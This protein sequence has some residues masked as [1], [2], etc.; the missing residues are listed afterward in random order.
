[1]SLSVSAVSKNMGL[2]ASSQKSAHSTSLLPLEYVSFDTFYAGKKQLP[3]LHTRASI[4]QRHVEA[5]PDT[6][7][8]FKLK[9]F[10]NVKGKGLYKNAAIEIL[11]GA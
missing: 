4:G 5:V 6:S 1:M 9:K 3:I 8:P 2:L 7:P 11:Q 10:A